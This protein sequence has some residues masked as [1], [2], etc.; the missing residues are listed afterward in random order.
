MSNIGLGRLTGFV[1]KA[2]GRVGFLEASAC[3][4]FVIVE[5]AKRERR[6]AKFA[7]DAT[8]M[9][10]VGDGYGVLVTGRS[11]IAT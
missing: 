2:T 6:R 5:A 8:A 10:V 11:G 7:K 9:P 1:I 4:D 3:A